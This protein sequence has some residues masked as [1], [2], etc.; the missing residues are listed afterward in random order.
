MQNLEVEELPNKSES[1]DA[2]AGFEPIG[3]YPFGAGK[4]RSYAPSNYSAG[5]ARIPFVA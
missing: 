2:E 1:K 4:L 5:D 3:Q